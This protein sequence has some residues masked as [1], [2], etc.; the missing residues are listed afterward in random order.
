[1]ERRRL[2]TPIPVDVARSLAIGDAFEISGPILCGRDAVLPR[3]VK[4]AAEGTLGALA[5]HLEGSVIFHTAVSPAGIGPTSSNKVEIEGSIGP[6]S[7]V[8][9]PRP[10]GQRC[11][12]CGERA[13]P[14][15]LRERLRRDASG[16]GPLHG[17]DRLA[18]SVGLPGGGDGGPVRGGGTGVARDRGGGPGPQPVLSRLLKKAHLLRWPAR[19]LAAAYLEYASLGPSRAV[20]HLDL[21]EQPECRRVFQHPV[22]VQV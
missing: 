5:A 7:A 20:L 2:Q 19:A 13:G 14:V 22:S 9:G 6:L 3:L 4:M 15:G 17:Q 11:D 21:F 16:D 1:M 18:A 12:C 10:P 8:G